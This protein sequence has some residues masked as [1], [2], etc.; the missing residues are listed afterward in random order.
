M[1][2]IFVIDDSVGACVAIERMLTPQGFD[3]VW[4]KDAVT[5]LR[6]VERHAPDLV[7]SDVILPEIDGFELCQSMRSNP[8]LDR[9]PVILISGEVNDEIRA[10][11][12]EYGAATIIPKPFDATVL[13]DA[14]RETL[15]RVEAHPAVTRDEPLTTGLRQR[16]AGE[17]DV[18]TALRCR[19]SCIADA[20]GHVIAAGNPDPSTLMRPSAQR[21]LQNICRLA[22]DARNAAS[23]PEGPLR[24]TLELDD[25]IRIVEMLEGGQ[26]LVVELEDVSVLGKSRYLMRRL[27]TRLSGILRDV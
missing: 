3:V 25:G 18:F 6:T 23:Q 20:E 8:L 27:R 10:R 2:K 4:E 26:L 17:L 24:L 21:A 12:R 13:V 9:V 11:A 14:V 22:V 7:I 15:D 16:L 19:F 1:A 5:A